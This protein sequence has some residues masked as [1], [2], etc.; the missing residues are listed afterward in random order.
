MTITLITPQQNDLFNK[1]LNTSEIG[2]APLRNSIA[3]EESDFEGSTLVNNTVHFACRVFNNG[4]Q[5]GKVT[6]ENWKAIFTLPFEKGLLSFGIV[7]VGADTMTESDENETSPFYD[8]N[9]FRTLR[10]FAIDLVATDPMVIVGYDAGGLEHLKSNHQLAY[11][12]AVDLLGCRNPT[13][14]TTTTASSAAATAST[15][16]STAAA[17]PDADLGMLANAAARGGT[18]IFLPCSPMQ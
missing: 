2:E 13:T 6:K 8:D 12:A 1:W 3:L 7:G 14:S 16:T 10:Q 4:S 15:A 11:E 9:L 17:T 5:K 18:Y